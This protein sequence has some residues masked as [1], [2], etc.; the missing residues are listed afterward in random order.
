[1]VKAGVFV[2]V[3]EAFVVVMLLLLL[4]PEFTFRVDLALPQ[5]SRRWFLRRLAEDRFERLDREEDT[6]RSSW[7]RGIMSIRSICELD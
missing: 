2:P 4:L 5:N 1:M 3:V 6:E 7:S